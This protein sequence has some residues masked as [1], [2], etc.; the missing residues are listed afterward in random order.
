MAESLTRIILD[1]DLAMG[2]PGSPVDDGFALALAVADP[3][4]RLELVTTVDGNSNVQMVTELTTNLLGVLRQ[5]DV[6]VVPGADEPS[7]SASRQADREPPAAAEIVARVSFALHDPLA[8]AV[9]TR[10]GLVA[11]QDEYVTVETGQ[12]TPGVAIADL[13][14]REN[15]PKANCRIATKV[16]ATAFRELFLERM[17]ALR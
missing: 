9:V 12:G 3:G 11:W 14:T 16:K 8:V 17:A 5:T 2:V 13:L 4:I 15:P 10:P 1:T 7:N 6:P